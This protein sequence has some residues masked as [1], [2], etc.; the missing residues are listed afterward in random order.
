MFQVHLSTIIVVVSDCTRRNI[1]K[2]GVVVLI[3]NFYSHCISIE[4][5]EGL[6]FVWHTFVSFLRYTICDS[7]P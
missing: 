6:K 3:N 2:E 1:A 4:I 5:S 7:D